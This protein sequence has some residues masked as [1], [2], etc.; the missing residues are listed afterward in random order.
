MLLSE[1]KEHLL[2]YNKVV[3]IFV[4]YLLTNNKFIVNGRIE[5]KTKNFQGKSN[6]SLT[7]R[8]RN[9]QKR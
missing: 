9:S 1:L 6:I 8:V 2:K 5:D 3:K 7:L 4:Y